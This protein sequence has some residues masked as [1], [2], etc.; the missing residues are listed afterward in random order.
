[1]HADPNAIHKMD[2]EYKK[3]HKEAISNHTGS[4]LIEVY[5]TL[6]PLPI[7]LIIFIW[8]SIGINYGK[9]MSCPTIWMFFIEFITMVLPTVFHFTML[10]EYSKAKFIFYLIIFTFLLSWLFLN[11]NYLSSSNIKT[12]KI[13]H[14]TFYRFM[15][16]TYTV[17]CIL[18]VDFNVFPRRFAKTETYGHGLMDIGVGCYVCSNAM[19][20]TIPKINNMTKYSL[21]I[22][23][24]VLPLLVL[25]IGRTYFVT[26]SDY[27][28]YVFEYGVHWNFFITLAFLKIINLLVLPFISTCCLTGFATILVVV[29]EIVLNCGLADWI[30]SDAPRDNIFSANREGIVSLIG[31]E[32]IFLYSLAM[33]W[34]LSIFMKKNHLINNMFIL[35]V[36]ASS[37]IALFL[38]TIILRYF[39]GVSRR[40]VNAGYIFW[41][42]S[43]SSYLLFMSIIIENSISIRLQKCKRLS[44]FNNVSL[45]IDS[46]NNNLLLF[47]LVGN[48]VTG[49]I[50]MSIFT[51]K[52]NTV[53]SLTILSL[54]MFVIYFATYQFEHFKKKIKF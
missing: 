54:Y 45:I 49:I 25:G 15:L 44:E 52:M 21:K 3:L 7:H 32:A 47:F 23:K 6:F 50:N 51:L 22:V 43:I 1:M 2:T 28:H 30:M 13:L 46:I 40:L 26:K 41:T 39:F 19:L 38:L 42:L 12:N 17:F 27:H 5:T 24:Q 8:M 9:K 11:H 36:T 14:M 10:S 20:F 35:A 48:I 34:H 16:N 37:T 4:S 33:K 31:Y 53:F 18:A 29:Y